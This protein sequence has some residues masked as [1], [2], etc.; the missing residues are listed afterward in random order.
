MC[1]LNYFQSCAFNQSWYVE[2]AY[3]KF[4]W[5]L[6]DIKTEMLSYGEYFFFKKLKK[7]I[8]LNIWF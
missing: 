4:I 7:L 8:I 2:N 5:L 6:M 3:V 1:A